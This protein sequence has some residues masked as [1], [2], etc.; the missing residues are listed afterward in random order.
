M[1]MTLYDSGQ[2]S[3]QGRAAGK[4]V[5]STPLPESERGTIAG[6]RRKDARQGRSAA[7]GLGD[8][9]DEE[10]FDRD[11]YLGDDAEGLGNHESRTFLGSEEKFKERE[12]EMVRARQRGQKKVAG[13]SARRSQ[14][15]V[16]QQ[17]WEESL[18][19]KSGVATLS[20]NATDFDDDEDNRVQ[21]LVHQLRPPF[22]DKKASFQGKQEMV[23]TVRD[24]T[25]DMATVA[26]NGSA[27]VSRNRETKEQSKMR[28]RY[29]ELGGSRI[30]D[31]MGI[32]KEESAEDQVHCRA[33]SVPP[34]LRRAGRAPVSCA[35]KPDRSYCR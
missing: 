22:L 16:D 6:T 24:P 15:N 31:A 14:L 25:S 9:G 21:I 5:D 3:G 12:Q 1:E 33:A 34:H 11:F 30:G 7:L 10:D 8:G 2:G 17:R 27:L 13:M 35:R 26:K 19:L 23:S 29:W 28:K 20:E 18:L 32:K 4:V